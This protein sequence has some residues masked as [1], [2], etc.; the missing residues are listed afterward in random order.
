MEHLHHLYCLSLILQLIPKPSIGGNGMRV[1]WFVIGAFALSGACSAQ[2]IPAGQLVR[3]V[4]YNELN[5][6]QTHGYWRYWVERHIAHETRLEE[7]VETAQGPVTRLALTN[8]QPASAESRRQDEERLQHLLASPSEQARHLQE[9]EEDEK[10]IGR[11]LALL[12][13]AFLYEYDGEENGCYR[14]RFHPNPD[15]PPHSIEA[16]IFH[17]MTG[18]LWVDARMKRLARLDGRV[19]ENIDF[20]YGILG[21]LYQGGWFQLQRVQVSPTDWKTERLE[22]HMM[23]RALL[24]KSFARETSEVRGGFVA[25]PAAMSLAQGLEVLDQPKPL[26]VEAKAANPTSSDGHLPA[27][28]ALAFR[29]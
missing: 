1:L 18:T 22:V 4:V 20:G 26:T 19:A 14:L 17:A 12:P 27:A 11:I 29:R 5:D 8:G 3:E 7:Q 6:H 9:Y 23:G 2:S 13:D 25:V 10:R 28:S 16:R 24:V 21:R 15:Y